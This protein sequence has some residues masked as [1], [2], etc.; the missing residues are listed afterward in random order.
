MEGLSR[1]VGSM[2][3]KDKLGRNPLM[4][5]GLR[6][7]PKSMHWLLENA[8]QDFRAVN[9]LDESKTPLMYCCLPYEGLKGDDFDNPS[10]VQLLLPYTTTDILNRRST[11]G[12]TALHYACT[13][14]YVKIAD[15]LLQRRDLDLSIVNH[16]GQTA[17]EIARE[18][19]HE[20]IVRKMGRWDYSQFVRSCMIDMDTVHSKVVFP[21][22]VLEGLENV[23][24]SMESEF[25]L[26]DILEGVERLPASD[27]LR[28][29]V[30]DK[31]SKASAERM[32]VVVDMLAAFVK[33][34]LLNHP[35]DGDVEVYLMPPSVRSTIVSESQSSKSK[36]V[37][38]RPGVDADVGGVGDESPNTSASRGI[39]PLTCQPVKSSLSPVRAGSGL[40]C[41][42]R[43]SVCDTGSS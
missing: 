14:G 19:G 34:G 25:R 6:R 30:G 22:G 36:L 27:K 43:E 5:A 24:A 4:F 33:V 16:A 40:G 38:T 7:R 10:C 15:R 26:M 20:E 13:H 41:R 29:F 39:S 21:P 28:V 35:R 32:P 23:L 37:G 31:A 12:N 2:K 18:R 3:T 17:V 42:M 1:Y 9:K 8:T 11:T